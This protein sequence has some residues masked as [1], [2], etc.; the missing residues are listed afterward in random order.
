MRIRQFREHDIV[1]V[2]P[3]LDRVFG[4]GRHQRTAAQLRAGAVRLAPL[5]FTAEGSGRILGAVQCWPLA[6]T[7]DGGPARAL[8]LLGPLAVDPG[9]RGQ[10]IG[11]RLMDATTAALDAAG[12]PAMLVGD[13]PY[14]GRWGFRA[15][16]TGSW[17]LPG[18]VE[19]DRLL[20]RAGDPQQWNIPATVAPAGT[21]EHLA[22]HAQSPRQSDMAGR[23]MLKTLHRRSS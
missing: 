6:W 9:L 8:V 1:A 22:D 21:L 15:E 19:P 10:G 20:L 14:Y 16:A 23:E 11:V 7:P 3:L 13:E 18:P 5:S 12:L 17:R 2:E 4:P